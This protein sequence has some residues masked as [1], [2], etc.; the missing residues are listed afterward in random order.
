MVIVTSDAM[1]ATVSVK[2]VVYPRTVLSG[3]SSREEPMFIV[4]EIQS[5]VKAK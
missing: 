4:F 5:L 1:S 3:L 2:G